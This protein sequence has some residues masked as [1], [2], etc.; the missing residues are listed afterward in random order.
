MGNM[1]L[2]ERLCEMLD[3]AQD[4]IRQQAELLNMHGIQTDTGGLEGR[5]QALLEEI[6]QNT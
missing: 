3:T 1:E 5:R 6:E 4:I 2:I